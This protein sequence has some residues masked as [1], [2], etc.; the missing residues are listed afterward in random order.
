MG[1]PRRCPGPASS[2][3]LTSQTPYPS[4]TYCADLRGSAPAGRSSHAKYLAGCDGARSRVRK[5]AGIDFPG[6]EASTSYLIAEVEMAEEPAWGIRRGE[7]GVNALDKLE[8]GR[9]SGI[10]CVNGSP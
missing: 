4:V 8:D 5:Q 7:K 1:R 6:W 2:S 3:S 9:S 10:L